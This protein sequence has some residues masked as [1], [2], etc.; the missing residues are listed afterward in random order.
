MPS[1]RRR[2]AKEKGSEWTGTG[3]GREKERSGRA[4]VAT[5]MS[6]NGNDRH[7][8]ATMRSTTPAW[9][10]SFKHTLEGTND[11]LFHAAPRPPPRPRHM[12]TAQV[13]QH[14]PLC[15]VT[16]PSLL[17]LLSHV[18]TATGDRACP[19]L[20]RPRNAVLRLDPQR[21]IP[22]HPRLLPSS[23][24]ETRLHEAPV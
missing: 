21:Y 9:K 17:P 23:S 16:R 10:T 18:V 3:T 19:T 1:E 24:L 20:S 5:E 14:R 2:R 8:E 4:V 22:R 13:D 12:S 11:H 15:V 6:T 7:V